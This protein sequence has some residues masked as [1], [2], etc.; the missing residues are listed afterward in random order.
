VENIDSLATYVDVFDF[1]NDLSSVKSVTLLSAKAGARQFNLQLLGSKEALLASLKLNKQL[2]QY[3]DPLAQFNEPLSQE[4]AEKLV[5]IF[6]WD[7]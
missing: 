4:N 7:N 3:I 2:R 5:P 1:L 6:Y